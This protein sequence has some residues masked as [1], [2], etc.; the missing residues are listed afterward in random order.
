MPDA[1]ALSPIELEVERIRELS[2]GGRHWEALVAAEA[3]AVEVPENR[4]VLYLLAANQRCLNRIPEALETLRRLEQEHPRFSLLYQER[5]HC[6][7]TLR[8][9]SRAI[10]AFLR[11]VSLNPALATSWSML[12]RL[13]RMTGDVKNADRAAEYVSNLKHL[14]PEVVKAGSLFSDGELPTAEEILR[15]Y[16]LKAGDHVEALRLLGRIQ[17]Q[18]GAL[19]EAEQLLEAALRLAPDYRAARLDYARIQFDQQKYFSAHDVMTSLRNAEPGNRDY[20]SLHA[21]GYPRHGQHEPAIALYRQLIAEPPES[22]DL[23]MALGHSLKSIGRQKEAI[24]S[25]KTAAAMR[26]NFGDAYW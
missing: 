11:G 2:K 4:E 8:D 13:Y 10:D 1:S 15:T 16:L 5:G 9:A 12:E 6:Y 20:R 21:A 23:H 24:E 18:R 25:Y 14:P 22:C 3:L 26:M 7:V 17:H 19:D